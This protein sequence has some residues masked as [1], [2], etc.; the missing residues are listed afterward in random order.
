[1]ARV[2]LL[3]GSD[4]AFWPRCGCYGMS[5]ASWLQW[6]MRTGSVVRCAQDACAAFYIGSQMLSMLTLVL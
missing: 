4:L 6:G 3:T 1:M 2:I 5:S